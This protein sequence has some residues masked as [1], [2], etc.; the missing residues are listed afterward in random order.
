MTTE[1]CISGA[2]INSTARTCS[3]HGGRWVWG[4]KVCWTARDHDRFGQCVICDKPLVEADE[5]VQVYQHEYDEEPWGY[6]HGA[7]DCSA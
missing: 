2:R 7:V 3:T 5:P 1:R 4:D 6:I